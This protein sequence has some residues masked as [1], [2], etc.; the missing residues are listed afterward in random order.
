MFTA[1]RKP[2]SLR[3]AGLKDEKTQIMIRFFF[4]DSFLFHDFEPEEKQFII[5]SMLPHKATANEIIIR[6]GDYGDC[7]YF[8]ESGVYECSIVDNEGIQ[9]GTRILRNYQTGDSFGELC[10]LHSARRQANVISKTDGMLY[11]INRETFRHIKKMS[12]VKKR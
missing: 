1:Q 3:P 12:I 8:V 4:M 9:G 10:L 6:E 5:N 7:M 2:I 11:C